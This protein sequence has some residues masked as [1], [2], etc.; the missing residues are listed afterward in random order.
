MQPWAEKWIEI[1]PI[2]GGGQGDTLLVKSKSG[3]FE[4]AVL[5]LLKPHKAQDSK[6]RGRM[7]QEVTN[8][9]VLRNAGGKVPQVLDGNTEKFE[10]SNV[11]LYFVMEFING[12]TLA[13]LVN[14]H[15]GLAAPNG[16]VLIAD[17]KKAITKAIT[18]I[19]HKVQG[20]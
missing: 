2:S 4:Q 11:P 16:A 18:I 1:R 13:D 14:A 10:D 5:K 15:G 20:G 3:E 9:K 19:S 7:A 17:L 6:A 12:K 8:L